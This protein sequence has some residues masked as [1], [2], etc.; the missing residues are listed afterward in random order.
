LTE[1]LREAGCRI[2]S[3]R[4]AIINY[5][6][7]RSDHP[8]ARQIFDALKSAEPGLSLATVYNT[9]GTLVDLGLINALE[10]EAADN[11]Y[12]THLAPH[13]NLI[14]SEC[15]RIDDLDHSL[16]VSPEELMERTGFE[17]RDFRI[18]YRGICNRCLSERSAEGG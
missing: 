12:D 1:A 16:P 5:L 18:E 13:I 8:S 11:R 2:T 9:L 14:C 17:A 15:D 7:G 6:A 3:Q 4:V 10:F